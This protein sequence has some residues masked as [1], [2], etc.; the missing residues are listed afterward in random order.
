MTAP[1]PLPLIVAIDGPSGTGK[2]SVSR[3]VAA[4]LGL[5]YLD[6]GAMYRALTWWCLEQGI[7]LA[8]TVAVAAAAAQLPLQMGMDPTAVSVQV[9]GREVEALLRE[10]RI[11][12]VV[13]QV[14]TNLAVRAELIRR[15]QQLIATA[16]D[17]AG[18]VVAEG[19]D[20]TTVV[21]PD[22]PVRLLLVADDQARLARRA[23]Q[24]HG[25]AEAEHLDQVREEVLRRDRDD[26]QVA[27][28]HTPAPGVILV[29]S[30]HLD[31]EQT[32]ARV[33]TIIKELR[34]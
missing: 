19:R 29:D 32:V 26:S 27:E 33:L 11:S 1:P 28:F 31:F 5:P 4:A 2:S 21:A 17:S 6:T 22:A 25:R 34:P 3:A 24:L 10:S 12:H 20:I 7:D 8:D 16:A 30:S 15:Q 23:A 18:G 14:A 9:A 13:S